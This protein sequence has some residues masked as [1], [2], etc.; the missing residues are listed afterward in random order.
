MAYVPKNGANLT[1]NHIMNNTKKGE[2]VRK[3]TMSREYKEWK[4]SRV[5]PEN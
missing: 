4:E 2:G 5:F 3:R 1:R